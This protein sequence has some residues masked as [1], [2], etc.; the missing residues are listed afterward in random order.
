MKAIAFKAFDLQAAPFKVTDQ[1]GL[2]DSPLLDIITHE[3]ARSD[4]AVSVYR[5]YKTRTFTLRGEIT[6][7][8]EA[9]LEA[10]IDLLKLQLVRQVGDVA[11]GWAGGTRYANAECPNLAIIRGKSDID[12]C[13]WSAPFFMAVP[14]TSDKV[15]RDFITTL[16]GA[17]GGTN[18]IAVSNIGTYLAEPYITLTITALEPNITDVSLVGWPNP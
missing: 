14:F 15:T 4:N 16:A 3:L 11:Y 18:I 17:T 6:T 8:S 13:A 1:T 7:D 10:S 12:R 5:K 9:N 2:Y